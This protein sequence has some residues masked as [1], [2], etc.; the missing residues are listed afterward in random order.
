[1]KEIQPSIKQELVFFFD[2]RFT[3]QVGHF[4]GFEIPVNS[5]ENELLLRL[6][7]DSALR[8]EDGLDCGGSDET[9]IQADNAKIWT[10][11]I[12]PMIGGTSVNDTEGPE[13][14][15]G[16]S[17]K[18]SQSQENVASEVLPRRTTR[19]EIAEYTLVAK[20][21][22]GADALELEQLGDTNQ[23]YRDCEA[24][25]S[26]TDIDTSKQDRHNTF[27]TDSEMADAHDP[28]DLSMA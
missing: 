7:S 2:R 26:D 1:M 16:M 28:T 18:T 23:A 6:G 3:Y 17:P 27:P 4:Y 15:P 24:D 14:I 5:P 19:S 10:E 22:F 13:H 12:I 25:T 8:G 9:V 20:R 11:F 21:A